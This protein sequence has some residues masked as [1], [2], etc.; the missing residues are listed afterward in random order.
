MDLYS[1]NKISFNDITINNNIKFND[2]F[3]R[4]FFA[5]NI[6]FNPSADQSIDLKINN[7]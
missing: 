2:G 3:S 7:I 1:P 6:N 5:I 4:M